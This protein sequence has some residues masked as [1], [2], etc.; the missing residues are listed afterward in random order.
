[1][2]PGIHGLSLS[3]PPRQAPLSLEGTRWT[4]A[5]VP[6][7]V[8]GSTQDRRPRPTEE[9]PS[10]HR[11]PG[12]SALE[13]T[14]PSPQHK[15]RMGT[16]RLELPR[17]LAAPHF[18]LEVFTW[19][20]LNTQGQNSPELPALSS[21][22]VGVPCLAGGPDLGSLTQRPISLGRGAPPRK[23]A[24]GCSAAVYSSLGVCQ[25]PPPCWVKCLL[26]KSARSCRCPKWISFLPHPLPCHLSTCCP[27]QGFSE[28]EVGGRGG[29]GASVGLFPGGQSVA[30][31]NGY[32]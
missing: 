20:S 3:H 18:P 21:L 5:R 27:E 16:L 2:A 24:W 13:L 14:E 23:S 8:V 10:E 19:Q 17:I 9:G 15:G 29:P 30:D 31:R 12:C 25:A 4:N 7:F 26:G 6:A 11:W 22:Q 28:G 32:K 1:M